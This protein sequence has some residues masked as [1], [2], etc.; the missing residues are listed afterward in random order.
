M[1][2]ILQAVAD[3]NTFAGTLL[4]Y[5][6][7][8]ALGTALGRIRVAGI[9]L[10]VTFILFAGL[11]AGHF[12][13]IPNP[14]ILGFL[15]DFGLMLF[16]FFIGLQV[17]P[18]FFSSF[19]AGG[20]QL[21]AL[22]LLGIFLSAAVTIALWYALGE[23]AALPEMLGM[24][25]GAVT[26]TPG[27]GAVQEALSLLGWNG[28]DPAVAYAC[29][30]PLAVVG[31][32]GTAA[33]IRW[34]GRIDIAEEDR[35][36]E[37]EAAEANKA[38]ISFCVQ[39]TNEYLENKPIAIIREVI[40]RPFVISRRWNEKEGLMSPGPATRIMVGDILRV[41]ALEEYKEA[42]VAFFGSEKKNLDFSREDSPIA[43][44][45][46]LITN[47]KI[48]GLRVSDLHLSNYEGT[49]ITRIYRA[50]MEL[51]PYPQL[52][53]HLGDRVVVVGPEKDVERL[54]AHLGNEEKML[55]HP[56][57]ISVF[58][59]IALGILVGSI[60]L[61]LPGIPAP[62]KLG[63]A[64]GPL[65]VAILLGRWGPSLKLATYTTNSASLMLRELGI[66]FFLASVGL[67]AGP[68]FVQAFTGGDGFLYMGLG[69]IVTIVPLVVIAFIARAWLGM[70]YHAIVG[71]LAGTTTNPPALAY[72][73][74]LSDKN[75][76]AV[77]YATVYPMAMF[78]RILT[79][80][81]LLLIFWTAA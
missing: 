42:V 7:V 17:G 76:A 55:D 28:A 78:L 71:L 6:V 47:P 77:A 31:I 21:N 51:F 4:I 63:L 8:I 32:I 14:T 25:Y 53:L 3:P 70:N 10:G 35:K 45:R 33:A 52:H 16:V 81:L 80:Q 79:G 27:L 13:F 34:V 54:A 60:P 2:E 65:V 11:A 37:M 73:A 39:A 22:A 9:S 24:H 56:N 50:G 41:V 66:S 61:A 40:G 18:S 74:T 72:A 49:N 5:A 38:P 75:S 64:G 30:Y 36:W 26:N 43:S 57:V 68:G 59:G 12:G 29:A 15:R 67:A 58:V 62:L 1:P 69:V 19:K 46:A 23:R 44:R 20:V 48:N